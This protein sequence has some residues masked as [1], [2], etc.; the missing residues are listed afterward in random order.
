MAFKKLLGSLFGLRPAEAA[1]VERAVIGA[2]DMATGG[3]AGKAIETAEAI[4]AEVKRRKRS[5]KPR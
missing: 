3:V 1:V 2:A 5:R 4:D